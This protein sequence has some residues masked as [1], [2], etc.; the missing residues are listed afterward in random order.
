MICSWW[1]S[2]GVVYVKEQMVWNFHI[3]E[4]LFVQPLRTGH[5]YVKLFFNG[6]LP[7]HPLPFLNKQKLQEWKVKAS[8]TLEE[9]NFGTWKQIRP[10]QTTWISLIISIP[11]IKVVKGNA[12]MNKWESYR[13]YGQFDCFG[14]FFWD[15]AG[16]VSKPATTGLL[17]GAC[18]RT[19]A[20]A[21]VSG[22][23]GRASHHC[24]YRFAQPRVATHHRDRD[25]F[26]KHFNLKC[27]TVFI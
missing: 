15:R 8:R 5:A 4:S 23:V 12:E 18:P 9:I 10:L 14:F 21:Q 2:S 3:T 6:V 1:N 27:P 16:G 19:C 22:E 25:L 24:R 7:N 17:M 26:V 11:I 13:Y 20:C